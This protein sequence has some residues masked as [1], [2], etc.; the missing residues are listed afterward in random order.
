MRVKVLTATLAYLQRALADPRLEPAQ[1]EK[2]RKGAKELERL[3][4]SGKLDRSRVFRATML[5]SSTLVEVLSL[6]KAP[7][8]TEAQ[9]A[10]R[11]AK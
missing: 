4:R 5:I 10:A 6:P 1:R 8:Q 11:R 3:R 9:V 2:L 7:T